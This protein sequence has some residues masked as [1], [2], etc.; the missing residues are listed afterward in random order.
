MQHLSTFNKTTLPEICNQLAAID[1]DLANIISEFGYP[2][3]WSREVSFET[4]IHII[5]EQQVSLASAK[6][7][8]VKLQQ[9]LGS[10]T[11]EGLVLLS[12]EAL[13]ACYFS[14]QKIGYAR[15]LANAIIT[16][17]LSLE[18]LET[19]DDATVKHTL[20]QLKG[21]GDWTVDVFLMMAL[22]RCNLFPIGDIAL[23]KSIKEVKQLSANTTKDAILQIANT[24]Q[25]Y[26][27]I[28]AYLLW[29]AYI[30]K[31]NIKI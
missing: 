22:H 1:A 13:K 2:Y 10:V 28:A 15:G 25:P 19:M 14:K 16:K 9:K 12:D 30:N 7:A 4:L 23:I 18:I 20:K 17:Q 6:A 5:L 29:W 11:P 24:W 31:R 21:I 3:F 27:T 26:R 8:L